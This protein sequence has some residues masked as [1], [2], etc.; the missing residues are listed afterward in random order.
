[1]GNR[2][3]KNGKFSG[4]RYA[5]PFGICSLFLF[6][7]DL[8]AQNVAV[9]P[10]QFTHFFKTWSLINPSSIG[11][12]NSMEVLAGNKSLLGA[13]SGVRTFYAAGHLRINKDSARTRQVLGITFVNDKEGT[14]IH[15]NRAAAQYAFHVP[16]GSRLMLGAGIAAGFINY[17]FS[18]TNV[19]AGGS[20]FAPNADAGLWLYRSGF[21]IGIGCNQL[22]PSKLTPINETYRVGRFYN[23]NADRTFL[24]NR[25]ISLTP[26]FVFRYESTESYN[27]DVA[28]IALLYNNACFA[29]TYK[30][31]RGGS[32]SG[33]LENIK[34][35]ANIFKLM[36][37]YY[38]PLGGTMY[39]NPQSYDLMLSLS[40]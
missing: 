13:F 33:G 19:G 34:I 5:L 29:A 37:S 18:T 16:L 14:F 38:T 8:N 4:L 17:V 31:K 15:R 2:D 6:V 40:R 35:G 20:A 28:L 12:A 11:H 26:A 23:L 21:N 39:F 24:I 7:S 1:M 22:I 30:Y 10:V 27:A 3:Y 32:I 9:L 36:I 25:N